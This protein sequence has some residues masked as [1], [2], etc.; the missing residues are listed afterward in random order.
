MAT[1]NEMIDRLMQMANTLT[2]DYS[3][4]LYRSMFSTCID[5]NSEHEDEEI[6]MCEDCFNERMALED[7]HDNE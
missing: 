1:R 6:F 2:R 3:W 7:K 5:W 4:D